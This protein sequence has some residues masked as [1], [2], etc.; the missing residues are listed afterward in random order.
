MTNPYA[1]QFP[2]RRIGLDSLEVSHIVEAPSGSRP[3]PE[4]EAAPDESLSLA[5]QCL[6]AASLA[7]KIRL[8]SD[9]EQEAARR[10]TG[11][12]LVP[13]GV[14]LSLQEG[15][16]LQRLA[17]QATALAAAAIKEGK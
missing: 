8:L 4:V 15:I 17:N 14:G 11:Q 12:Y 5:D 6:R 16:A 10:A 9:T 13:D 7:S 1:R 2:E 3:A